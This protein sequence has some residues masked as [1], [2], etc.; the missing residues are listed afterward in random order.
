MILAIEEYGLVT[1]TL[2]G[3]VRW[4]ECGAFLVLLFFAILGVNTALN[5]SFAWYARLGALIGLAG[6][7]AVHVFLLTRR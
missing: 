3:H 2:F 7:L 5:D 1:R 6:P 4:R